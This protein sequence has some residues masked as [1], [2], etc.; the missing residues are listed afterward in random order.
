MSSTLE[1]R[2]DKR[3]PLGAITMDNLADA[4]QRM[5][6]PSDP[7]W[8]VTL[9]TNALERFREFG[10]PTTRHEEW[11]YTNLKPIRDLEFALDADDPED[12][13]ALRDHAAPV[14]NALRVFILNGRIVP[15]LS[16]LENLP[17]GLTVEPLREAL[18]D[19]DETLRATLTD[20]IENARDGV[21]AFA[22]ALLRDGL[23]IR[24]ADNAVIDRP[25]AVTYATSKTG[26]PLLN[27]PRTVVIAG[28]KSR[29]TMVEEHLG[30]DGA[31]YLTA[32]ACD[33]RVAEHARVEHCMLGRDSESAYHLTTLR[34]AQET[35]SYFAS[36]RVL[37][38]G[39]ITRNSVWSILNGERAESSLDGLYIG[40]DSQ[41]L[42]NHMRVN[43]MAPNCPSRQYY[44]GILGDKARGVFTGRIFVDQIAQKT[45][46]YQN[47]ANLLLSDSAAATARPQ[48]EIYADDVKCSHG[49]TTG[50]L[51]DDALFY[52]RARG[53]AEADARLLLL[54]A[55]AGEN[56]DRLPIES[57][58]EFTKS[59]IDTRVRDAVARGLL[60]S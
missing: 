13:M 48:L 50:E 33:V 43:H 47:N 11:R 51:N 22:G 28:S 46:A 18:P 32:G 40:I 49:A 19:A 15:E 2:S 38:G 30:E 4:L 12:M 57:L 10:L 9:R 59:L 34:I 53:I 55:F 24:V 60:P 23:V 42:D 21:E 6:E 1:A 29:L 44:R 39:R 54:F 16:D 17:D 26:D 27:A 5:H 45:D 3:A 25:L 31:V 37:T 56:L 58:R 20:S 36:H 7:Q 14:D 35:E 8:L 52:L 41:H